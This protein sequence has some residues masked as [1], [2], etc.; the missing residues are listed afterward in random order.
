M[1]LQI[2]SALL[3]GV[4]VRVQEAV[5]KGLHLSCIRDGCTGNDSKKQ[6]GEDLAV[7]AGVPVAP[8]HF[9]RKSPASCDACN[10]KMTACLPDVAR[11]G[12]DREDEG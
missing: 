11:Q 6:D 7:H 12:N 2:Y 3:K 5:R 4:Q 9:S 10:A 8:D 1:A